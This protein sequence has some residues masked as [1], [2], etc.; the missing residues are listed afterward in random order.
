LIG[1]HTSYARRKTHEHALVRLHQKGKWKSGKEGGKERKTR[2]FSRP[3]VSEELSTVWRA[4][5]LAL[6]LLKLTSRREP[7]THGRLR[8]NMSVE[9]KKKEKGVAAVDL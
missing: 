3:S 8:G 2:R 1:R 4:S 9:G 6:K 7:F 5:V